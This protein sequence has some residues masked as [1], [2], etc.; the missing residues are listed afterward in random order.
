MKMKH[1]RHSAREASIASA[2]RGTLLFVAMRTVPVVA[3]LMAMLAFAAPAF[4]GEPVGSITRLT[5]SAAVIRGGNR[6]AASVAMSVMLHDRIETK[7]DGNLTLSLRGGTELTLI[8]SSTI[9]LDEGVVAEDR[10][11]SSVIH[12]LVGRLRAIV[13]AT[14]SDQTS[15]LQIRTSNAVA[16][17]R[18]TDFEVAF[19]EGKPCPVQ[20]SCT[21][22]TTVGVYRG[23][24]EVTNPTAPKGSKGVEVTGGYETNVPCETPPTS[25]SPWGVEELGAPGYH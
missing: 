18:G 13:N 8:E 7:G 6:L 1:P 3:I 12:L 11:R 2:R 14:V 10:R 17:V 24:V 22:Y 23:K 15:S 25:P 21:R 4:A 9:E 16:A 5:G 20:P 19:I